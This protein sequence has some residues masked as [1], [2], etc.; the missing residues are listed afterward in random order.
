M[1]AACNLEWREAESYLQCLNEP[2][3]KAVLTRLEETMKLRAADGSSCAKP[4]PQLPPRAAAVL[5]FCLASASGQ[6]EG[7]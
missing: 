5:Y 1:C 3:C 4:F 2:G 6:S 7:W